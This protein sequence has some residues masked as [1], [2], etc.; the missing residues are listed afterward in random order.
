MDERKIGLRRFYSGTTWAQTSPGLVNVFSRVA[1]VHFLEPVT[2]DDRFDGSFERPNN[3]HKPGVVVVHV[4]GS[5]ND[6][7][8]VT[9]KIRNVIIPAFLKQGAITLGFF[10][11]SDEPNNFPMLPFVENEPVSV[12]FASFETMSVY[13]SALQAVSVDPAPIATLV[14]EP[15][16]RSRV[17][18]RGE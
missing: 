7:T 9:D 8:L 6:Q 4:F 12:W 2:P 15:G 17:Y 11:S 3:K 14:L 5:Q 18:H 16:Q 10:R 13:E 1:K